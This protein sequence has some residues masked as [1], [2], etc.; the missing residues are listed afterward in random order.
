MTSA[1]A[2]SRCTTSRT[3]WGSSCRRSSCRSCGS[4]TTRT[5]TRT[6]LV[7]SGRAL[8]GADVVDRGL[9]APD[10]EEFAPQDD[11]PEADESRTDPRDRLAGLA[12][13]RSCARDGIRLHVE[14]DGD[15]PTGDGVRARPHELLHRARRVHADGAGH[16]GPLLL[17]RARALGRRRSPGRTASRTSPA[18]STPSRVRTAPRR[19]SGP[20]SARVRSPISSGMTG[21]VRAAR[22]PAAGR[23][24][25]PADLDAAR[26][27]RSDGRAARVA[28]HGRGDRADPRS[29]PGGP[30]TT[31]GGPGSATSICCC[32]RT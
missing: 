18:T 11:L 19:R 10:P 29:G 2:R 31:R 3:T 5:R 15:G 27:L 13:P 21:P 30:P 25:P 26:R 16:E 24:R 1:G 7:V 12:W 6:I 4:R 20:R 17:P 23:A 28:A 8:P 14:V 32:G 9:G 22:V